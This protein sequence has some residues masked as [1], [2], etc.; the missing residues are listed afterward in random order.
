MTQIGQGSGGFEVAFPSVNKTV[1]LAW[2]ALTDTGHRREVNEDS[3]ISVPPI[4]AVADGMGG[5]SAGDVASAAVVNRL[6]ELAGRDSPQ[7]AAINT[8]LGLAVTDMA[9]GVGVTDLG[10]GTTVTGALLAIVSGAPHWVVF[11]IGDSRVYLLTSGVLEQITVDH[12]VVQ[13]AR[14]RRPDHPRRSGCPPARQY[15]HPRRRVPRGS[16]PRLPRPAREPGNA[17]PDLL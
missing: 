15:H 7:N 3:L 2:A 6:A 1:S 17:S 16:G 9:S 13:E 11:N 14:G 8:A 4:F 5:H 12:S 10:T